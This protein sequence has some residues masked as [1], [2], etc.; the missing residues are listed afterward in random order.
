MEQVLD[1]IVIIVALLAVITGVVVLIRMFKEEA[2]DKTDHVAEVT[3]I[4][5]APTEIKKSLEKNNPNPDLKKPVNAQTT[6]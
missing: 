6:K 1:I 2:A 4:P 5:K 3:T